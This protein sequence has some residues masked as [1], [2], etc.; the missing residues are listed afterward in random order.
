MPA[1][2]AITTSICACTGATTTDISSLPRSLMTTSPTP[3]GHWA[4]W[5]DASGLRLHIGVVF[6]RLPDMLPQLFFV[7]GL[8]QELVDCALVDGLGHGFQ[9]GVAGQHNAHGVRMNGFHL[10]V[11]LGAGHFRHALV[12]NDH[13]YFVFCQQGEGFADV[14]G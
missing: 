7:P 4:W 12:C 10:A 13:L 6:E 1:R 2:S 9:V 8:G 5:P 3:P 11:K 14:G